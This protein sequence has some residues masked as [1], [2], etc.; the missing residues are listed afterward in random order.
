MAKG[1]AGLRLAVSGSA[2]Q[3]WSGPLQIRTSAGVS[4]AWQS[5]LVQPSSGAL[6][7]FVRLTPFQPEA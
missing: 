1:I 4:V 7:E 5:A 3:F 6:E 2:N